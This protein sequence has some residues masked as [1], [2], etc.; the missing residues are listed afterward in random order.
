M[1]R[2]QSSKYADHFSGRNLALD[3]DDLQRLKRVLEA[4]ELAQVSREPT[5]QGPDEEG[6]Q[7]TIGEPSTFFQHCMQR[8]EKTVA[9]LSHGLVRREFGESPFDS[10]VVSYAAHRAINDNGGWVPANQFTSLVSALIHCMQL[11]LA[12]YCMSALPSAEVNKSFTLEGL[13]RKECSQ[14]LVNSSRSPIAELS[15]WRLMAGLTK[16]DSV[17]PPTTSVSDDHKVVTHRDLTM[18]LVDWRQSLQQLISEATELLD[19]KLLFGLHGVPKFPL[20]RLQD[21]A[22]DRRPGKS[23][24]DCARNQLHAAENWLIRQIQATSQLFDRFVRSDSDTHAVGL[25]AD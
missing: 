9:A 12:S 3:E 22:S 15:Y 4:A 20:W 2:M 13:L 23:F 25:D 10:P 14:F 18:Q 24:L 6:S 21:D 17:T 11:W 1:I 19:E 16:N 5:Q 7:G 8:L